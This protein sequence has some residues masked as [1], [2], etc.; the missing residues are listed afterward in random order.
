MSKIP[1]A[2]DDGHLVDILC[3]YSQ[4]ARQDQNILKWTIQIQ[5]QRTTLFETSSPQHQP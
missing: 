5:R 3:Q 1:F 2:I 4:H